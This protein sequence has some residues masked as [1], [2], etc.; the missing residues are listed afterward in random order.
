MFL[1]AIKQVNETEQ[2]AQQMV[3]DAQ[4]NAR[5]IAAV[6]Q[7]AA[8]AEMEA[9]KKNGAEMI[10]A[11]AQK[12]REKAAAFINEQ[13]IQTQTDCEA[14]RKQALENMNRAVQLVVEKVVSNE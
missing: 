11:A 5:T 12:A 8:D 9:A 13:T 2:A 7:K 4:A 14:L 6:A 3:L 1:E 10:S